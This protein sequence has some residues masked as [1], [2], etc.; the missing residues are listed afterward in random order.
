MSAPSGGPLGRLTLGE[1]HVDVLDAPDAEGDA[2]LVEDHADRHQLVPEGRVDVV[3]VHHPLESVDCDFDGVV[4]PPVLERQS[5]A[6]DTIDFDLCQSVFGRRLTFD[7][8][9]VYDSF[10][11]QMNAWVDQLLEKMDSDERYRYE[12]PTLEDNFTQFHDEEQDE[13]DREQEKL[14]E[15]EQE[16]EDWYE[17]MA[18]NMINRLIEYFR[19]IRGQ[20]ERDL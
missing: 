3:E 13:Y 8:E 19:V 10:L 16:A 17:D 14:R 20:T 5:A 6:W 7:F 15:F 2:L 9:P 1:Q 4:E 11:E 18:D 12:Q